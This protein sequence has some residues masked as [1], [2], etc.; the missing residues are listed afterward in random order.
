MDKYF[1]Y[2]NKKSNIIFV[3]LI[4]LYKIETMDDSEVISRYEIKDQRLYIYYL[5]GEYDVTPYFPELIGTL[6]T[7]MEAQGKEFIKNSILNEEDEYF[8]KYKLYFKKYRPLL[9]K[10]KDLELDKKYL[11]S[12]TELDELNI[13]VL[14]DIINEL[15]E[16]EE[17]LKKSN[18]KTVYD[19]SK[20]N[21]NFRRRY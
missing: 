16:I 2:K 4:M 7:V 1:I 12:I 3:W 10:L 5:N 18:K 15:V 21:H 8:K 6:Q 11:I 20:I 9:Y 17:N 14:E 19:F 13:N